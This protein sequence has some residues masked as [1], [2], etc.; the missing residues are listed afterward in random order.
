[1]NG[2]RFLGDIA[3]AMVAQ[4]L[5]VVLSV[6]ITLVLPKLMGVD[7]FGYWQL[8]VFYV[9]FVGFFHLGINDGVYLIKGGIPRDKVDKR[10]INSEFWFSNVYQLIFSIA[11]IVIGLFGPFEEQ[12]SFVI[13]TTG[14]II[15][16]TNASSFFGYVF[17]AMNETKLFSCSSAIDSLVTFI[18]VIALVALGVHETAP[19]IEV[20]CLAKAVRLVFCLFYARDFLS[21]GLLALSDTLSVTLESIRVGAK[22]M[23]ANIV[24]SLIIGVMRFFID[25]GWGINAFS[26]VSFSLSIAQFFL[27]FLTQVSMVL[28][29]ALRQIE[30][31]GIGQ[32]FSVMQDA[33]SLFLPAMYLLYG[34]AAWL[35]N[36]WLPSYSES[37][38]MFVL[39]FPLCVF[40]GKMDILGTTYFKVLRMESKLMRINMVILLVST[41]IAALGTLAIHS[42]EFMLIG[43]VVLLA[44]RNMYSENFLASALKC[45]TT[46]SNLAT[47]VLSLLF[48]ALYSFL[49]IGAAT[50]LYTGCYAAVLV[51]FRKQALEVIRFSRAALCTK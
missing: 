21:S 43:V 6:L 12:R 28:F 10:E 30:K 3:V 15:V 41:A 16:I 11:V 44:F 4:G 19:Y 48:S 14:A 39:L 26:I 49:P 50:L 33:L 38:K 45:K 18:G 24:G 40:D 25:A 51:I 29:P 2:R 13:M 27:M 23:I 37:I 36:L 42:V 47:V 5:A 32:A 17:Q 22:L 46:H 35:L 34:P 31:S 8:F 20:Y 7:E 9:S 1:M